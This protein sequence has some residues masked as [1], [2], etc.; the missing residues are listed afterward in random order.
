M[1]PTPQAG[2][3]TKPRQTHC[4]SAICFK[5]ALLH[6]RRGSL[7]LV[8]SKIRAVG[9]QSECAS[10]ADPFLVKTCQCDSS[11]HCNSATLTSR[12]MSVRD[13]LR[14]P[15]HVDDSVLSR[16]VSSKPQ[17]GVAWTNEQ[18]DT[19][20]HRGLS[21]ARLRAVW[22]RLRTTHAAAVV[23]CGLQT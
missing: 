17:R 9:S 16:A 5:V 14:K 1:G 8:S 18:S 11:V 13:A 22:L 21:V 7:L 15:S 2:S 20:K 19:P 12:T 23:R 10:S 4:G 3:A 6:G